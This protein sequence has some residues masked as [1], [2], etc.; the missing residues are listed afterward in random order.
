VGV[1]AS[2]DLVD[3]EAVEVVIDQNKVADLAVELGGD[4]YKLGVVNVGRRLGAAQV[5]HVQI[6]AV[7]YVM[8]PMLYRPTALVH[9]R[10]LDCDPNAER[11]VMFP[12]PPP[13]SNGVYPLTVEMRYRVS[14]DT[15]GRDAAALRKMLA[16]RIGIDVAKVF[17]KHV[18]A[19]PGDMVKDR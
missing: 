8:E 11:K 18:L 17:Y 9:V 19:Q 1:S 16:D 5:I 12:P 4:Y 3:N 2:T 14:E 10:V 15:S 7:S 6:K 13:A